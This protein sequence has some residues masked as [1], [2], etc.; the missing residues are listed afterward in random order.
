MNF[1]F[2]AEREVIQAQTDFNQQ[3]ESTKIQ[4]EILLAARDRHL[5]NL[6]SFVQ[7]Q[8]TYFARCNQLMLELN[9]ELQM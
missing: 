2:Q 5:E 7:S 9:K 3:S 8:T 1:V 6:K 4:L